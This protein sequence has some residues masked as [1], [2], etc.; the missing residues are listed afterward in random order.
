[1][2]P[3]LI[4]WGFLA[5]MLILSLTFPI[6]VAYVV[7]FYTIYFVYEAAL[8][9][10]L[11]SITSRKMQKVMSTNWIEKLEE[12]KKLEHSNWEEI[13][14]AVMIC[15]ANEDYEILRPT[16]QLLAD[17][18]YPAEKKILVLATEERI[19][20]GFAIATQLKHEF[21]DGFLDI[22]ITRHRLAP[23]EIIGK[24]SN[25][26]HGAREL[27]I[28]LKKK[29][30]DTRKVIITTNDSDSRNN[31][32]YMAK[33]TYEFLEQDMPE[34]RIYQPIPMFYNNI[35]T[36]PFFSRII[37][38]FSAQWQMSLALK[39][40]RYVNFSSYAM[41]M[42]SLHAIGYWD[43]DIIPE[44]ERA[45]W[46]AVGLYGSDMRVV[47]L[48]IPV[49]LDAVKG[50]SLKR[51]FTEQYI[52]IRRWAWGASEVAY[53]MQTILKN[54][55]V[56]VYLQYIYL[57]QQLRKSFEWAIAPFILLFGLS[58]PILV[59]PEFARSI[60]AYSLPNI[61]SKLL[62][63]STVLMIAVFYLEAVFAPPKP[64][65]WSFLR[66]GFSFLSW[67]TFPFI[68]IVFS[69]IPALDAQT[70]LLIGKPIQYIP[71]EKAH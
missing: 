26:N 45:Y 50:R 54:P 70:R 46:K 59:N 13:H 37:A 44:D 12:K 3:G 63:I 32:W 35:W 25:E 21:A 24:A 39:P 48:F 27:Y 20:K 47:P 16:V 22:I 31:I 67:I 71:T 62:T 1:M 61:L 43:P 18:N 2:L 19:E 41:C 7:M 60:L 64:T 11:M 8:T 4:T 36:V 6:I 42:E 30:I 9:L 65:E 17:N 14:H 66:K 38:T 52:Q 49:F 28:Y 34:R 10:T 33:L 58:F 51:T 29:K 15:F 56:P 69:A 53:S 55:N 23:G 57:F 5:A 68:S 40:H